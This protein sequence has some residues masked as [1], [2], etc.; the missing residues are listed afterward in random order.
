MT[1]PVVN[2]IVGNGSRGGFLSLLIALPVVNV[3]LIAPGWLLPGGAG[4]TWLAAEAVAAVALLAV[5][6]RNRWRR[7]AAWGGAAVLLLGSLLAFSDAVFRL[8]LGR[9]LNLYL[10]IPLAADVGRLV[11]GVAGTGG[12]LAAA[13]VVGGGF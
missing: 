6:P 9:A 2:G 13:V 3:L 7:A 5:L 12:A 10:D 1:R 8:S 4:R 11:S